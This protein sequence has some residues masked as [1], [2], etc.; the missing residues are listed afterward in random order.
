MDIYFSISVPHF[1]L[2]RFEMT[3]LSFMKRSSQE[4]EECYLTQIK[5]KIIVQMLC[6]LNNISHKEK[7]LSMIK[8]LEV[9]VQW[10]S[11]PH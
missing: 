6:L 9:Y 2:N 10:T 4:E 3:V 1:I 11:G 5:L 8:S 7:K